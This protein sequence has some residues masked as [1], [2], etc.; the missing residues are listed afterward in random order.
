MSI[1]VRD[2]QSIYLITLMALDLIDG[3]IRLIETSKTQLTPDQ[4]QLLRNRIAD[5][6]AR[7]DALCDAQE[8]E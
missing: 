1:S 2:A 5:R 7:L 8:P 4:R 6:E 3:L